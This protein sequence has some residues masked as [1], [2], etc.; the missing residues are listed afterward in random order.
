MD[1]KIRPVS[2]RL[3]GRGLRGGVFTE[4]YQKGFKK[5]TCQS[6]SPMTWVWLDWMGLPY[7]TMYITSQPTPHPPP[8]QSP[9]AG[10][11]RDASTKQ[12]MQDHRQQLSLSASTINKKKKH[13]KKKKN[14]KRLYSRQLLGSPTMAC[15]HAYRPRGKGSGLHERRQ[16]I[17]PGLLT[18]AHAIH[19]HTEREREKKNC[20]F[21]FLSGAS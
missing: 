18:P 17:S 4:L 5:G 9:L 10:R 11:P 6:T 1:Q 15:A 21:P 8:Q 16:L 3:V 7:L 19:G 20:Y 14:M 13:D 2:S 12:C